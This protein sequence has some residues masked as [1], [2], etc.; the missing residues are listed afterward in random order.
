MEI[1]SL[2]DVAFAQHLDTF[3]SVVRVLIL[4][5]GGPEIKS[6]PRREGPPVAWR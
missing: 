1:T 6:D 5:I 2:I 4:W 3:F